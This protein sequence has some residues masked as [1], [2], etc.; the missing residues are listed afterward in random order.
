MA[1]STT[2]SDAL[3]ASPFSLS[4][5]RKNMF[6]LSELNSLTHLH[7][8]ACTE[9]RELL[10][11]LDEKFPPYFQ[12]EEVPFLPVRAFKNFNLL[13]VP[14]ENVIKTMTSSGTSGQNVSNIFLDRLTSTLQLKVLSI[15]MA[16]FIGRNR[17]PML[18]I[19]SRSTV[20]NRHRFSA[21][22]AGILG[23]STFGRKVEFALRDDM[24]I[25]VE[26]VERFVAEH[27]EED[28]LLFGFTFIVWKQFVLALEERKHRV[29]LDRGILIHGGGWKQMSSESVG[30][31]EFKDR[32][33]RSTGI[34][35]VHNYYGMVEQT[36]SIFMEC[37]YG[38][39]HASTFSE[40]IIRDPINFRPLSSHQR[41]LIQLLSVLPRSYPGHSL[42]SE[43][44]GEYEGVD[45]CRCGR[46]GKY[47]KVHGRIKDAEVRGCSDTYS[48]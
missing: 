47:F 10:N 14:K 45:D 23:F 35:R 48:R 22:T 9:Y 40:V 28:I 4:W 34:Q 13:S 6:L 36:G 12:L 31:D 7:Y 21:R 29:R 37:Q 24:S 39:F 20:S 26:R 5:N 1:Y 44:V 18:V 17:L 16:D 41:G 32:L 46:L 2:L 42:L 15:I 8:A 25:D 33:K 43:D 38:Y 30:N 11:K 3:Q 27:S 19:D